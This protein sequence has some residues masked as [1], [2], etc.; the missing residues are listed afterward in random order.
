MQLPFVTLFMSGGNKKVQYNQDRLKI[1]EDYILQ[2][3][4]CN[5]LQNFS[6]HVTKLYGHFAS[7]IITAVI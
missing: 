5:F 7:C 1:N 6:I 3:N 4:V 2:I